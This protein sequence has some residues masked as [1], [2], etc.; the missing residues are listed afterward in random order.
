MTVD[1]LIEKL[2]EIKEKI[3][4]HA[5]VSIWNDSENADPFWLEI[6]SLDIVEGD[7]EEMTSDWVMITAVEG[8]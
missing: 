1:E 8:R 6:K 7:E 5:D 4:G 2:A 3:G